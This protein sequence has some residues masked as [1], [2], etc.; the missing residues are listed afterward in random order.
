MFL[1]ET[2]GASSLEFLVREAK[3]SDKEPLMSFIKDVWGGHDYIPK[4]WDNWINDRTAKMFV[5]ETSG[6]PVAMNR[7]RFLE[8]GSAWFEGV[9]VHPDY[10]RMGLATM[11]GDNAM[12]V[13]AGHKASVF[14]LTTST[15]NR[16]S[17]G[18][19][20]RMHFAEEARFSI[21]EPREGARFRRKAGVRL[22]SLGD[23]ELVTS[24][25]RRSEEHRLGNGVL[26][27]G[28]VAMSLTPKIIEG[29]VRQ[30]SVYLNGDAAAIRR[31]VGEGEETWNQIG[32][33]TGP[34]D[35]AIGLIAHIFSLKGRFD[36]RLVFVPQGSSLIGAARKFG[37]RRSFA[38]ILFERQ[39]AKG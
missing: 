27:D 39:A 4:V 24:L 21:Y 31:E 16:A 17:Q 13:A 30:K 9:R 37:L 23:T 35:Y 34:P 18:Q 19:I 7:V 14:R 1:P 29:L 28:F 25:I 36:W 2:P 5:V 15:R 11:L 10:R 6:R 20:A 26:W 32:F 8:D 12:R 22:A 33:V 38:N 3:D